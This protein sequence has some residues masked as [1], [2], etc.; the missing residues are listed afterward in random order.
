MI[1]R[2]QAIVYFGNNFIIFANIL[3]LKHTQNVVRN[4]NDCEGATLAIDQLHERGGTSQVTYA[5]KIIC[6]NPERR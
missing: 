1:V 5:L 2:P 3:P 6:R 4:R